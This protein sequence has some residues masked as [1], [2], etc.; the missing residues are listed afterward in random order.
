MTMRAAKNMMKREA[1]I[2]LLTTLLLLLLMSSLLV[3]FFLLI[4]EGQ[5]LG[6]MNNDYSKAFYAAEAGMEKL[7]ADL[8]TLFDVNYSPT[9]AQ[10]AT[11]QTTPP[12]ITGISYLNADGTNGYSLAFNPNANGDP[13]AANATITSGPYQG[14]TALS[15]PYTLTVTARTANGSEVKLRRFTQTIGIPMFQFG[16][17]SDSDLDFF[18]GPVFNFGGRTHTNGNLFL[19][20]GNNLVLAGRVT[21]FKD[22]IRTNLENGFPTAANYGGTV[23]ITA[24][25]GA[26]RNLAMNEGSLVGTIGSAINPNWTNISLGATNYAGNL[27]NGATGA[28]NLQLGIVTLG[29]GA[30]QPIDVL[31]RPLQNESAPITNERYFAQASM[32]VLLSDNPQDIMSLPCIDTSK[33]PFNLQDIA[34]DPTNALNWT[35]ANAVALKNQMNANNVAGRSTIPVPMATSGAA[36][37][38]VA[39]NPADGYWVPKNT[40]IEPGFIKIEIQTAYGNPC[41]AWRD[42]TIEVLGLG[43][44][45]KNIHPTNVAGPGPA[46]PTITDVNV[47]NPNVPA[48]SQVRTFAGQALNPYVYGTTPNCYEPHPSAVIRLERIRDNPSNPAYGVNGVCG[49]SI[50]L[51]NGLVNSVPVNPADY[52]PNVLFDTREGSLRDFSP[53]TAVGVGAGPTIVYSRM[54]PLNGVF[55]YV[56]VDARN[57]ATYLA[58]GFGGSGHLAYDTNTAPN[59]Y[60]V[61]VSDRR[62]NYT[63]SQNWAGGNTWPPLS[64]QGHETGEYGWNDYVNPNNALTGCPNGTLDTGED[65]DSTNTLYLYGADDTHAASAVNVA[66]PWLGG[67]GPYSLGAPGN[68]YGN[69]TTNALTTNP[70]CPAINNVWPFTMVIHANDARENP[71]FFV[72]RAVKIVDGSLLNAGLCPGAVVCGLTIASENPTYI[73]GDFNSNSTGNG[74]NDP[75]I[76]TSVVADAVTLLSDNWNDYNSFY[77]PYNQAGVALPIVAGQPQN[78]GQRGAVTSFYRVAIMGGKTVYFPQPAGTG[79]DYGTDG[80]VHNFL[81]YIETWGGQTLNYRGSIVS[82][83]FSRQATGT[84]K[85]CTL[86]YSPPT[87]GYNFDVEFLQPSLLP[88]RTPLFRDV[89]TTG[90]S[91]LLLPNQQ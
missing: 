10:L 85:C 49:V 65:L 37:A 51:G 88:P 34:A 76:A 9:G 68:I 27:R 30:T 17:F 77:T 60:T 81:R 54:V 2:A 59:D 89:N 91:Q 58:G 7:T 19:A 69:A 22:V 47:D 50:N 14:M 78:A 5:K 15:T 70:A 86:V 25:S 35:S 87:R 29:A 36:A 72:R 64:P 74:F 16:V 90:F 24:G 61:Y 71:L 41:G 3:G 67:F 56:E 11:L 28:H 26:L 31:R 44:A 48:Y 42:V 79:N 8:G 45:G 55:H 32:K 52:W 21:A 43:Y 23:N 53:S 84:F 12:V 63:V 6:T 73:E 57:L 40:V 80:G 20:D 46:L 83:F 4:S 13:A 38:A 33:Q 66:S 82:L 1:G 39:Y 18:P 75:H 62:G